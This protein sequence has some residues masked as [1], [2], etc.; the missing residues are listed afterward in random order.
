M[1]E[2]A[3]RPTLSDVAAAAGLS[4]ATT[5]RALSGSGYVSDD[6]R[7]RAVTAA[8]RLGYI[9]D[10]LARTLKQQTS[11]LI[12]VV[13]SDLSNSFYADLAAG[14]TREA[15]TYDWTVVLVD[16]GGT[17]EG[18][19]EA[20]RR[21]AAHRVAGVVVTPVSPDAVRTADGLGLPLVEADRSH[22]GADAV[23]VDNRSGAEAATRHLISHGARRVAL[24]ADETTWTSGEERRNGFAAALTAA[25]LDDAQPGVLR[26]GWSRDDAARCVTEALAGPDRPDAIFAVNNLLTAG[27]FTAIRDSGLRIPHDVALVGFDDRP[28]MTMVSPTVTTVV[29]DAAQVG[30]RAVQQLAHRLSARDEPWRHVVLDTRLQ[31]RE[32]SARTTD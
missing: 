17:A 24:L 7:R 18:E 19:S 9:P 29:Q 25:G 32:S 23:L 22:G 8:E 31:V 11:S 14:A 13:V 2:S 21:L 28:W 20:I 15:R 4:R 10:L 3:R 1:T 16:S 27:A 12:G 30:C 5:S 6:A 26:C